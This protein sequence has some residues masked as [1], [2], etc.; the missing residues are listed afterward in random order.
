M[1]RLPGMRRI[2]AMIGIVVL[3]VLAL[4]L[5]WRVWRH[6]NEADPYELE[7]PAVVFLDGKS[8]PVVRITLD[9]GKLPGNRDK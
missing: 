7:T 1:L 2:A 5:F 6:H 8:K 3:V 9:S 4:T